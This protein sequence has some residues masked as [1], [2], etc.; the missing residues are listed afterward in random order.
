VRVP[1]AARSARSAS[2]APRE[3]EHARV[4]VELGPHRRFVSP[5]AL[6][7]HAPSGGADQE[8]VD[9]QPV[10]IGVHLASTEV[11]VDP[12][13]PEPPPREAVRPRREQRETQCVA[14]P[15]RR[16]PA[17]R[18]EEVVAAATQGHSGHAEA[19]EEHG[20]GASP[21]ECERRFPPPRRLTNR[22]ARGHG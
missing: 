4:D 16:W 14:D 6:L 12:T 22:G 3:R 1:I 2:I 8:A 11:D 10:G 20:V 5:R 17:G 18:R 7:R 15:Q 21:M 19:R 9:G 13:D